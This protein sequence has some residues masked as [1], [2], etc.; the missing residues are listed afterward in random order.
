MET[1]IYFE[2]SNDILEALND[3]G[4]SIAQ[5]LENEGIPAQVG[6]GVEPT[7]EGEAAR[8]KDLVEIATLLVA[9]SGLILS[10]AYAISRTLNTIYN[11]P[12][13]ISY[14]EDEEI[15]DA[16]GNVLL[17]KNKK[18]IFKKVK[19][20]QLIESREDRGSEKIQLEAG[21]AITMKFESKGG[22]K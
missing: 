19:K 11:K 22:G 8:T 12:H 21:S 13:F 17:D 16:K 18:P 2:L 4:I 14:Y 3:N 9:S 6:Y 7:Y 1:K 20:N 15:R 10:I 5:I